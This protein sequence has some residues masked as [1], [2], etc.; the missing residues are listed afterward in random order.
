MQVDFAFRHLYIA[1]SLII[2]TLF[3]TLQAFSENKIFII[4]TE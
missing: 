3:I 2:P 4:K 1:V